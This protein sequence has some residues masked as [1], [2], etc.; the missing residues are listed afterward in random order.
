MTVEL[1][2]YRYP[3]PLTQDEIKQKEQDAATLALGRLS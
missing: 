1:H 3:E 2:N